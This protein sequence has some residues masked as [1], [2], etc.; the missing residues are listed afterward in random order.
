MNKMSGDRRGY[1]CLFIYKTYTTGLLYKVTVKTRLP[2]SGFTI[3]ASVCETNHK[4]DHK[5]FQA[6]YIT[7]IFNIYNDSVT[8]QVM[9]FLHI[10]FFI[11]VIISY[12]A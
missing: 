5:N 12:Q 9:R 3:K 6:H 2:H 8:D 10:F 11:Y 4:T 7:L 1:V